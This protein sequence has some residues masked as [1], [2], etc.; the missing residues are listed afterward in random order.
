MPVNDAEGDDV[1]LTDREPPGVDAGFAV[2]VVVALAA[3]V[4]L[5]VDEPD[6]I[7][8]VVLP[9]VAPVVVVVVELALGWLVV[10]VPD[11]AV[12]CVSDVFLLAEGLDEP[13]A[14]AIRPPAR[15]TTPIANVRPTRRRPRLSVE[16]G[17]SMVVC[18]FFLPHSSCSCH[19]KQARVRGGQR[20]VRYPF[21]GVSPEGGDDS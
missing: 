5:V 11:R 18:K 16:C 19:R 3:V 12:E 6:P 2:V 21:R 17:E 10:V 8:V 20:A 14:A 13:H 4:V 1:G 9:P 7:V 15:T